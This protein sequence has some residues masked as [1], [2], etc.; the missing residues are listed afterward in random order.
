[1]WIFTRS[2]ISSQAYSNFKY[3]NFPVGSFSLWSNTSADNLCDTTISNS[4][5]LWASALDIYFNSVDK[6]RLF[7]VLPH[8]KCWNSS[9]IS[10]I[11]LIDD[12]KYHYGKNFHKY[13]Y[14]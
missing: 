1:M 14:F 12:M 7:T 11:N 8:T 4:I 3:N 13:S 5:K 2:V 6:E 10:A 9:N